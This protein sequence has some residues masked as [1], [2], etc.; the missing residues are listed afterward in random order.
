MP[1]RQAVVPL[2]AQVALV[3]QVQVL[4]DP[5]V[6]LLVLVHLHQDLVLDLQEPVVEVPAV[7]ELHQERLALLLVER[8]LLDRVQAGSLPHA[9]AV[10]SPERSHPRASCVDRVCSVH[11]STDE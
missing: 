3:L 8:L 6:P 11:S 4:Q 1:Q 9:C 5:E 7:A 2:Q 10:L